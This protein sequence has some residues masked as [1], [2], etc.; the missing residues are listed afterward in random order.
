MRELLEA[1]EKEWLSPMIPY[2]RYWPFER[3]FVD[4]VAIDARHLEEQA[5]ALFSSMPLTRLWVVLMDV[6]M[7]DP[8][9][10]PIPRENTLTSLDLT[11]NSMNSDWLSCLATT[12]F[13]L[14]PRVQTLSL[15]FNHL[16]DECVPQLCEHPFYQQLSLIRCGANPISESGRERLRS[17]FGERVSFVCQRDD[18]H[19]YAMQ[20]DYLTVGFGPE[21]TQL[22]IRAWDGVQVAVFDHE[23]NLLDILSRDV[24]DWLDWETEKRERFKQAWM[25]ELGFASA[26]IRFKRF[27]FKDRE[28]VNDFNEYLPMGFDDWHNPDADA[29]RGDVC[30]WLLD[31]HYEWDYSR[32]RVWFNGE[33]KVVMAWTIRAGIRRAEQESAS[34][35]SWLVT[36]A[37]GT[38]FFAHPPLAFLRRGT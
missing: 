23:G 13:A 27:K 22:L 33:G 18:D 1:G 35:G 32:R 11:Y 28:G 6:D 30:A 5:A 4:N 15:M 26:T 25:R 16:D 17:H 14:L 10:L 9:R 38:L 29:A 7:E 20:D 31:G 36:E 24:P 12:T 34:D 19:L 3:G 21:E 2:L 8:D 37:E